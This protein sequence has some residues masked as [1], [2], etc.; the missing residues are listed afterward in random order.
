MIIDRENIDLSIIISRIFSPI[1]V[2]WRHIHTK[3]KSYDTDSR[4]QGS[5]EGNIDKEVIFSQNDSCHHLSRYE[6]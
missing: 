2:G 6:R 3:Y 5:K 1:M 4:I